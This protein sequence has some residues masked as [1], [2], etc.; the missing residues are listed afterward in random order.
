MSEER[1]PREVEVAKENT[2]GD[3]GIFSRQMEA[4]EKALEDF[5]K[6]PEKV[7]A[8]K[9]RL[10]ESADTLLEFLKLSDDISVA[11]DSI[12]NYAQRKSD[13]DTAVAK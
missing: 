9:G 7:A 1:I 10:G 13:E 11:A 2:L 8:Y 4:W 6:L 12:V 3:R 5:K